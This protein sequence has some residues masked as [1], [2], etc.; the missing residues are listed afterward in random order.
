MHVRE[1]TIKKKHSFKQKTKLCFYCYTSTTLT[2]RS[3]W[4]HKNAKFGWKETWFDHCIWL[5]KIYMGIFL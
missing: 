2:H 4:N 5:L 3:F 1:E